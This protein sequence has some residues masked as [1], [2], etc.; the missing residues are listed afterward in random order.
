MVGRGVINTTG[1]AQEVEQKI[2]AGAKQPLRFYV[3][4][5]NIGTSPD[6]FNVQGNA[7]SAGFTVHYFLGAIP[8][9]ST[10]VTADVESGAFSTSTLAP[11]ASTS[12]PTMIR[13]EVLADK[14]VVGK[15]N[16]Q[17]FKLTFTSANDPTKVDAVN[18][19]VMVK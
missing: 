1:A 7:G 6:N 15:G 3:V 11:G 10:D 19:T 13:V 17:T 2:R 14:T 4:V 16:T 12:V 8:K 5:Q 18:A 9:E